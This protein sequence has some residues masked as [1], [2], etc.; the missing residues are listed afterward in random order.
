MG[1]FALILARDLR[2]A[3]RRP[4]DGAVAVAFFV[5]AACLFPFG[6]GA[7]P[8]V[9]TRIAPGVLWAT[10]LLA[11]L[12]PL[13]RLFLADAEDGALDRLALAPNGL[14]SL[15]L[16]KAAAHWLSV[17]LPL[18]AASPV[19]ALLLNMNAAGYGALLAALLLGTP[20]LVLIGAVAA[21]LVTGAR[22]GGVLLALLALPLQL[23]VLIFGVGAVEAAL[24]GDPVGAYL[25]VLAGLLLGALVVTPIAGAAALK[26][27]LE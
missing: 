17:G 2:L 20:T 6:V 1:G 15:V 16:A 27:A 13:E 22:R 7:D 14:A 23:P 3:L 21:A 9:L 8:Q 11:T 12:L 24:V 26:L 25:Q 10:A 4:T 5:I 19:V 18:L